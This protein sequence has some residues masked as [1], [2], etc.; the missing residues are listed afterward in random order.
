MTIL[1]ESG[2]CGCHHSRTEW[3]LFPGVL[4]TPTQNRPRRPREPKSNDSAWEWGELE[5]KV[6]ILDESGACGCHHSHTEWQLISGVLTT[7]T[8][9]HP[10]MDTMLSIPLQNRPKR[11]RGLKVMIL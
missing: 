3:Q 8:Q 9:N 10:P 11:P 6:A 1:D 5:E 4:T 7:R 2:A